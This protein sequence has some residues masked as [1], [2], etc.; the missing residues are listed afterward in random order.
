[1]A[2][3]ALRA[4]DC[5]TAKVEAR[6]AMAKTKLARA[7]VVMGACD[8]GAGDV[9]EAVARYEEALSIEPACIDAS[10]RLATLLI[11]L[12]RPEEAI[13]VAR[14][15]LVHAPFDPDLWVVVAV[16][17]ERKGDEARSHDAFVR[18]VA[19]FRAGLKEHEGDARY[20]V[21]FARACIAVGEI[22][23]AKA[24][25]DE[26]IDLAEDQGDGA[27]VLAEAALAYASAGDPGRCVDALDDALD[28]APLDAPQGS[29][30]GG[31]A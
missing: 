10:T 24:Q 7:L 9:L 12:G 6:L 2:E 23:E 16:G 13:D 27:D 14:R 22:D 19:A 5:A 18:A 30:P 17:W 20:R 28:H 1:R 4:H 25:L 29:T 15:A 26:A 8:E 11:D 31:A 3:A 21:R